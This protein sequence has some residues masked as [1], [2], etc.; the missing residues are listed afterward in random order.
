VTAAADSRCPTCGA[1]LLIA[2]DRSSA[3]CKYCRKDVPLAPLEGTTP[4]LENLVTL[5]RAATE[6]GND[7]EAASLWSCVL[8]RDPKNAEAWFGKAKAVSMTL[9]TMGSAYAQAVSYCQRGIEAA[10]DK[11]DATSEAFAILSGYLAS[12]ASAAEEHFDEFSEVDSASGE[13]L[14]R[15]FGILDAYHALAGMTS[16]KTAHLFAVQ[17]C[18]K[19][20]ER[21][22]AL[23]MESSDLANEIQRR[24]KEHL[25]KGGPMIA[26]ALAETASDSGDGE[27]KPERAPSSPRRRLTVP[28][29]ILL[30]IV[31]IL[32]ILSIVGFGRWTG[33]PATDATRSGPAA[34][35]QQAAS[36]S[37]AA[38][39]SPVSVAATASTPGQ[40]SL[41][42]PGPRASAPSS[43]PKSSSKANASG[44]TALPAAPKRACYRYS[45]D[46][47]SGTQ[48]L[49]GSGSAGSH[50][51]CAFL[52]G[53]G[54][55]CPNGCIKA[56]AGDETDTKFLP[57]DCK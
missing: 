50:C 38:P 16:T 11:D 34:W 3:R 56:N 39:P 51:A 17:L 19:F 5:A 55:C 23:H 21:L 31:A 29:M 22:K 35:V 45:S 41:A 36:S 28:Q 20:L 30:A 2:E 40:P 53:F 15:I 4:G 1:D 49:M 27:A 46:C 12:M 37:P 7:E 57:T 44:P 43:A 26:A 54:A 9:A 48:S 52:P 8:E 13:F 14:E 47:P 25:D 24:R 32:V 42:L 18:D 6:A 33:D 10:R